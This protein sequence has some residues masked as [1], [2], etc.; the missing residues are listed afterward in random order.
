MTDLLSDHEH[1]DIKA[2]Q[3]GGVVTEQGE[4][5]EIT[6][7]Y[8][9]GVCPEHGHL[10]NPGMVGIA[11]DGDNNEG[12]HYY[13]LDPATALIL[14]NRLTRAANL[15]LETV[16]EVPDVEREYIRHTCGMNGDD[17]S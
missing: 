3:V 17:D 14:A 10:S 16:E 2:R 8:T 11:L 12:A 7:L 15:V 6:H 1:G 13:V 4:F 5:I 9:N